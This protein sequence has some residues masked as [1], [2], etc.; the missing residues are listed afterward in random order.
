MVVPFG[1]R[2]LVGVVCEYAK[3]SDIAPE[4]RKTILRYLDA[5]VKLPQELLELT[6]WLSNY[7][8]HP[9]G[10]AVL[11]AIP[12]YFRAENPRPV[13]LQWIHTPEGL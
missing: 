9:I 12:P 2:S 8:M 5:D 7:Y 1:P 3:E 10:E 13:S 6:F 4:K 11:S